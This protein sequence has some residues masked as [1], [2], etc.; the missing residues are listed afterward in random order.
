M[1]FCVT[2]VQQLIRF[3]VIR[4]SRGPS[5]VADPLYCPNTHTH[6]HTH[7]HT[8]THTQPAE[9]ITRPLKQS[10]IKDAKYHAKGLTEIVPVTISRRQPKQVA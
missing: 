9:C 8:E 10:L 6:P 3:Q 4:L 1:R 2:Y 5:T 7:R